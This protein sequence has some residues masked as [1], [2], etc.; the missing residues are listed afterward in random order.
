MHVLIAGDFCDRY[1]VTEVIARGDY[2]LLFDNIAT[3]VEQADFSIVNFEFPI[4]LHEEKSIAKCGPC[5]QGQH[6][7]VDAVKYAGFNVC[8]LANNHILDYGT[9]CCLDTKRLLEEGGIKTVGIGENL[10]RSADILYIKK[11][12]ETL[13]IINCCEHEFSIATEETAGANPLNPIQL[14]YKIQEARQSADYVLVIVHGG[15]EYYQLPS[16][17]MKET[18]RFFIDAGADA[19]IN[20]HQHCYS[21][22]EEYKGKPIFYGL[23]NFLFDNLN[24]R[25]GPWT[26]GYMVSLHFSGATCSYELYPYTQCAVYPSVAP[27]GI[28]E[29][30][31]FEER[32]EE[33]NRIIA[34]DGRLREAFEAWVQKTAKAWLAV[35][36]PY[37]S[38]FSRGL[39]SHGLLPSFVSKK[40][41]LRIRNY[42]NCESHLDRLRGCVSKWNA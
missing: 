1:R 38:R 16:P 13:A 17:R 30:K 12:N 9:T 42:L 31:I 35:F 29:R 8:T 6:A 15:H 28:T 11:G 36:E 27:M 34:D 39:F 40:K 2:A 26:E 3:I 5:L 19:V 22:Y 25:S 21:G 24:E 23:G 33:L 32:I 41:K 37:D 10:S 20:H 14:Y 7:A 4:V 18:Y